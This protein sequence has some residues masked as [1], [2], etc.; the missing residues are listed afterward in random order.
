MKSILYWLFATILSFSLPLF[1]QNSTVR[2][3]LWQPSARSMAMGGAGV[4]V[5]DNSFAAFYNPAALAFSKINLSTSYVEP[6]PFLENTIHSLTA[7]AI[8]L[9]GIGVFGF[10][11]NRFW[12]EGQAYTDE[13]GPEI[14]GGD[15]VDTNFFK[16]THWELKLSYAALLSENVSAGINVSFLKINLAEVNVG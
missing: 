9:R 13:S 12:M 5:T 15:F 4:A 3:M 2:F 6:F 1:S 8:P 11:A 16:S 14:L 10:S 7:L